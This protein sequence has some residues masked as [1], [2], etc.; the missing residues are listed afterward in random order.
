M[1][2][3]RGV[4]FVARDWQDCEHLDQSDESPLRERAYGETTFTAPHLPLH[5]KRFK[6]HT[7]PII[8]DV[9]LHGLMVENGGA[10]PHT[11]IDRP[12]YFCNIII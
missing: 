8:Q 1:F 12:V 11:V 9:L 4:L 6:S 2:V 3:P 7:T 10:P 5:L